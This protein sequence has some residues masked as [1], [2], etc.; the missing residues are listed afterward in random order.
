M[1]HIKLFIEREKNIGQS[2]PECPFKAKM[3]PIQFRL[4]RPRWGSL[5]RSPRP[6]AEL[7]GPTSKGREGRKRRGGEWMRWEGRKRRG[8]EGDGRGGEGRV[9]KG[10][11]K[12][13]EREGKGRGK[14]REGRGGY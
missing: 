1:L 14:G 3:H 7:K 9:G 6:L 11:G 2:A 10:K 13:G 4:G 12:G 8:R 5:Q